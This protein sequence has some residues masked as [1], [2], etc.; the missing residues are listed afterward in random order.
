MPV[1]AE[2]LAFVADQLAEF[3]QVAIRRMFGEAGLFR[4]G[5]MFGLVADD[6]VYFKV[7]D[8]NRAAYVAAGAKPFVY[9][10]RSSPAKLT[11]YYEVPP[12]ILDDPDALAEW[13]SASFAVAKAA[14]AKPARAKRKK[15]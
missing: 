9:S 8:A 12:G 14:R 10:R 15:K 4:D 1:S 6:V 7:G 11:S 13:A 5:R 2:F 3:G